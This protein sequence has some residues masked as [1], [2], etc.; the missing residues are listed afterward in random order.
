VKLVIDASVALIWFLRE[1][2]HEP[3]HD[4]AEAV[5]AALDRADAQLFAPIHWTAEVISVLARVRPTLVN[6]ALIVLDDAH[7]KVVHG[8]PILQR[9]AELSV[10]LN[11]HLF[12]T[13]Y[14]A[15]ALEEGATLITA[16]EAY[17]AKAQGLGA[18]VPLAEFAG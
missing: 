18:I 11:H 16:D 7:P 6:S 15:V 4:R 13:L 5:A 12:D 9:A 2:P 1:L 3:D 8:L 14:H 10:T 17:L